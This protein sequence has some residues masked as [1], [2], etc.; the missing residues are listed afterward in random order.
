MEEIWKDI[1]GYEGYYQISNLGRVKSLKR[2]VKHKING[3]Y[4]YKELIL[5]PNKVAFDYLQVTLRKDNKRKCKYVHMWEIKK[6]DM[7]LII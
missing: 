7:K 1:K 3:T 6:K 2:T 4:T 5:K